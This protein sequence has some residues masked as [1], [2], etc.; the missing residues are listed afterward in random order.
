MSPRHPATRTRKL[1]TLLII[2][3]RSSMFYFTSH[4]II[5]YGPGPIAS[6]LG[7]CR[8]RIVL[9]PRSCIC[10]PSKSYLRLY[11]GDFLKP[12]REV[13]ASG[14]K[15]MKERPDASRKKMGFLCVPNTFFVLRVP[16]DQFSRTQKLNKKCKKEG[17]TN[18][19]NN[20]WADDTFVRT[21]Y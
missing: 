9:I 7:I 5:N 18:K 6:Q 4:R 1:I 17:T 19:M 14:E 10:P 3:P 2:K 13:R 21:S 12:R 8:H 16:Y 20:N 15:L 11:K